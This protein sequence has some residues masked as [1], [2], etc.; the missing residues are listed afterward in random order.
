MDK[1]HAHQI[2][3]SLLKAQAS[4]EEAAE[5]LRTRVSPEAADLCHG[6][7][8]KVNVHVGFNILSPLFREFPDLEPP[9]PAG[10]DSFRR[11]TVPAAELAPV[12]DALAQLRRVAL[13]LIP[14]FEKGASTRGEERGYLTALATLRDYIQEADTRLAQLATDFDEG[15]REG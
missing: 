14:L 1:D 12:R 15:W 11:Y 4:L 5:R 3:T 10:A 9:H 13:E 7:L 8:V 6:D 2:T